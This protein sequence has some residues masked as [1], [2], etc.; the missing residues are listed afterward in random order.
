MGASVRR[1]YDCPFLQSVTLRDDGGTPM[2]S[3]SELVDAVGL[4][5]VSEGATPEEMIHID[6]RMKRFAQFSTL[7]QRIV[8]GHCALGEEYV[9]E[10]QKQRYLRNY[11]PREEEEEGEDTVRVS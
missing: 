7:A 10:H 1:K 4:L 8:D 9:V 11:R 6:S 2:C 3:M 5:G